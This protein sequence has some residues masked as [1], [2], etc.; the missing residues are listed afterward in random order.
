[1]PFLLTIL[2]WLAAILIAITPGL[3]AADSGG[4]LPWTQ[5]VAGCTA[6]AA[7]V[8]A[9]LPLSMQGRTFRSRAFTPSIG[10]LAFATIA[11]FQALPLPSA[12]V[13]TIANE[14]A[15][16]YQFAAET[17]R[18]SDP[19]H[20]ATA[21]TS[22]PISIAPWLTKLSAAFLV[23]LAVFALVSSQVFITR[24][25][26][27]FLLTCFALTGAI[28]AGFGI[29][30]MI[31]DPTATVW[32]IKSYYGGAP[33]GSYVSRSSA[34][35]LLNLG[36]AC[37]IGMVAWRLA[38]ITGASLSGDEFPF[39]ELLDV[40]F[41]RTA[42]IGLVSA[43]TCVAGLLACG[44]RG[45][46]VGSIAGLLLAFGLVQSIHR[47][48]GLIPSLIAIALMAVILLVKFELPAK[49]LDRLQETPDMVMTE[50]GIED[51]RLDHWR[52]S[53]SAGAAQPILGWGLGT[54][55]Y[56][57]LPFQKFS[58]GAWFI[59][60]DNLW[61]EW[62]VESG[63]I[64][65]VFLLL[66]LALF[67][68]TLQ[69]LNSS[70]DPID[71][72]LA[73]AGW[74]ALGSMAVSQFFDFGLRVPANSIAATVIAAA[75]MGR[76]ATIGRLYQDFPEAEQRLG[77]PLNL[78]K[79]AR[80]IAHLLTGPTFNVALFILCTLAL[81]PAV[82]TLHQEASADQLRR[83]ADHLPRGAQFNDDVANR[84]KQALTTH[85]DAHP[86]DT[87]SQLELSRLT[88]DTARYAAAKSA[89]QVDGSDWLTNYQT[90]APSV[91]RGLW[92]RLSSEASAAEFA[93]ITTN[94]DG[95]A[96]TVE[97]SDA[98]RPATNQ[99]V[100]AYSVP[101]FPISVTSSDDLISKLIT[102][103]PSDTNLETLNRLRSELG[104][105]LNAARTQAWAALLSCPLC[106]EAH[107]AIISLDFAGGSQ[108]QS[109]Q[110]LRNLLLLRSRH[111]KSLLFAGKLASQARLWDLAAESW[112]ATMRVEPAMTTL[113]LAA[114]DNDSPVS[115]SEILPANPKAI[116]IAARQ[117][118][119]KKTPNK[120]LL[121][122]IAISL[123]ESLPEAREE[124]VATLK[125]IA[126]VYSKRDQP[127][128]AATSLG[129]AVALMPSD[130]DLR[131]QYVLAL[132]ESGNLNEA[133]QQARA[134]R[135]IN[136]KDTRFDQILASM[137]EF[138]TP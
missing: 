24:N 104:I 37:G 136:P 91:L 90:L 43:L 23:P 7:L 135:T 82:R 138:S 74:F 131:Y 45:G 92:Y 61:L 62:F 22:Y 59:N 137:S 40:L 132:R 2:C 49:S 125:L 87:S 130:L 122:R 42:M 123:N 134:G 114:I 94:G 46:L 28:Q 97:T 78:R 20:P 100:S 75:A 51:G 128:E 106:D 64:G 121:A 120:P 115:I 88:T 113:V 3:V 109:S 65:M 80:S 5:W 110:L 95:V 77:T 39:A 72:G 66:A 57:Y 32:G 112:R 117:E 11:A 89:S 55:R 44:S 124:R 14:S 41:D 21:T 96:E 99:D 18:L 25:R 71:H 116:A 85:V 50:D 12:W 70:P 26:I 53:L 68:A 35:V 10:L 30:Q 126:Q 63:I 103:N 13:T 67:C 107:S 6:V 81:I 17:L 47:S 93:T 27:A 4:V 16:A 8:F 52:D 119:A 101:L 60:A 33:F 29:Y 83:L 54:Y 84:I 31:H 69:S 76:H 58:S 9:L 108:Q 79:K 105:E 129:Q 86:D 133:R 48:R 118:V 73:T 38:A 127:A 102:D 111:A 1:L 15:Q 34:A 56:A 98:I 19:T 36:L